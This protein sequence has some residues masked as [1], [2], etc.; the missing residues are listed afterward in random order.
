MVDGFADGPDP[1][2]VA[3]LLALFGLIW[4]CLGIVVAKIF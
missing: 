1:V 2:G 3:I 4:F